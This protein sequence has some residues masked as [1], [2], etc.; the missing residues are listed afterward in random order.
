MSNRAWRWYLALTFV[1][2]AG[3]F[4]VP[5]DT[6]AQTIYAELVGLVATGAI[7]VGVVRNR[8]AARAAWWWFAAGQLLNV[9]G[10]LAE[11]ILGRVLHLETWPS[12]A[13]ILWLGL[14]PCLVI[15]LFLLIRRRTQGH[16][17][18]SLVDATTVTTGLGLLSWVFLIRPVADD[19][20][21]SLVARVVSVAYPVG[22]ILVLA[23]VTRLLVGAGS[24]TLAFRLLAGAL[25][26][27]LAGDATWAV[28][29]YVGLEPS[30]GAVKLLQMDFLTAYALFGAAGLHRS[31][32]EVG[33]QATQRTLRL[34][35]ALL[36]LLTVASLIAPAILGYQVWQQH[37]TDGVAIVIGSVALFLLVVTRMAQLLR[38][39]ERQS[40]QLSQLVRVD[41]LT[42][43]RIGGPGRSSCR[44]RSSGPAAT[45]SPCQSP[46]ST[47]TALNTSTTSTATR[48]ATGCSR[49]PPPHGASSSGRSTTSP[50][51]AVRSSSSCSQEP[52]PSSQPWCWNAYAGPPR[53]ARPSQPGWP[54]GTG[55][56]PPK[57]SSPVPT[58]RSMRPKTPAG[59]ESRSRL[60]RRPPTCNRAPFPWHRTQPDTH[61]ST[62]H[63]T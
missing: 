46:C 16:D 10:T 38:Q 55:T 37:V 22:D 11:A 35:P 45:R 47:S 31:V 18:G 34:S 4:L 48:Q 6:W 43:C 19:S 58:K 14:Y 53:L 28:I 42:G 41:D 3:Y 52:A 29:N 61:G 24:R 39:I 12:V 44:L 20:S 17:W 21:L 63:P 1:A 27:Y 40:K 54:P 26:L 60:S 32:R 59:T 2:V 50:A 33:E 9:V 51:T 57:S 8:P 62:R 56:R 36:V 15:G 49:P 5:A 30:P 7:V 25:L 13:D 23:M